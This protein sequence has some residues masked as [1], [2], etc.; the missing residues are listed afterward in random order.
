MTIDGKGFTICGNNLARIFNV[1]NG[2]TLTLN[3]VTVC[4]G[5]AVDGSGV[6]IDSNAKL[7]AED[8]IFKENVAEKNG[9]AIYTDSGEITLT[10]CVLDSNDVTEITT[11][12][13]SGGA[14][15]YAKNAQV[16]LVN[17]N[18]TNNGK[19]ELDRTNNDLVN[20]VI[21]LQYSNADITGGLF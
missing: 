10:N 11:N 15:I 5:A 7:I 4:H 14:A 19:R 21:N 2:A 3:N 6:Y 9:G 20:A 13:N 12:D 16:T 17:T 1:T 18:V 8:A